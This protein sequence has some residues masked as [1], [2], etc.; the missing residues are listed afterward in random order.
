M[1]KVK[2]I[3][4]DFTNGDRFCYEAKNDNEREI[5]QN[6]YSNL[7]HIRENKA[8]ITSFIFSVIGLPLP[9][10]GAPAGNKP[11]GSSFGGQKNELVTML[12]DLF[13]NIC[14]ESSAPETTF[15]DIMS[16]ASDELDKK[17]EQKMRGRKAKKL[18]GSR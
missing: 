7:Q 18:G 12:A 13:S 3:S 9:V 14:I 11:A 4:V 2:S 1:A 10:K 5:F 8:S 17:L 15:D 6:I 16:A